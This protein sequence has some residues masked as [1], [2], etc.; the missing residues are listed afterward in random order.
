MRHNSLTMNAQEVIGKI[1]EVASA[2][3]PKDA[4]LLLYG[5]RARGD[6]KENSDWDLL[7]LL[8]K[9]DLEN[10]DY[11]KFVFPFT[12]LGWTI[13]EMII[14]VVYSMKDWTENYYFPF[15]QNVERDKIVLA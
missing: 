2:T 8:N 6:A 1:Q 12:Y 15:C 5:S 13:G 9:D 3:L 11:D 14:P 7:I 10:T 4:K